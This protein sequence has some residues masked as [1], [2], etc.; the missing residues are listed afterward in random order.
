MTFLCCLKNQNKFYDLLIT[1]TKDTKTLNFR[2]KLKRIIPFLF[3]MLRFVEKHKFT[4]LVFRKNTFSCVYTNFS[5]FLALEHKFGLVYTLKV[6]V[7]QLCLIFPNFIL[8][9]KYLRKHFTKMHSHK[10]C[11]HVYSKIF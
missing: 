1:W 11:W 8:N 10:I 3:S 9:L 2:L 4:T 5:S 6:S 7:S